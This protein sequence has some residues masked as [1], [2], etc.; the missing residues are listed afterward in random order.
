[1]P[2]SEY[3]LFVPSVLYS[4]LCID[5]HKESKECVSTSSPFLN[6]A[7]VQVTASMMT[8]GKYMFCVILRDYLLH[9]LHRL[10]QEGSKGSTS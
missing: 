5:K 6:M 8:M 4:P 10:E 7:K 2:S 9:L 1:V 3:L